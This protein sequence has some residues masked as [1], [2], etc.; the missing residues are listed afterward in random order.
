M[1]L[2]GA[3]HGPGTETSLSRVTCPASTGRPAGST[4]S[5]SPRRPARE[6]RS[7]RLLDLH[8]HQLAAAAAVRASLGREVP[9]P[10]LVVIGVHTPEFAF[11]QRR[12]Q[13]PP[14]GAG[15]E[16]R[17]PGRDRQRLRGL[18]CVREPVLA[19]S[20]LRRCAGAHPPS[21]LRRRRLQ[22]VGAGHPESGRDVDDELVAV[23]AHGR[24]SA[25]RLGRPRVAGDVRRLC[26]AER[27]ASPG[28]GAGTS[29]RPT[30]SLKR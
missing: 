4:R 21:P 17:L 6:G 25:G 24:R 29:A 19:G 14:G 18:G 13:R 30:P 3:R 22:R 26:R 1:S 7:R 12:R 27:F 5:R 9:R 2:F 28:G 23:E 20:L 11:E 10:G 15:H 16:D 8:L